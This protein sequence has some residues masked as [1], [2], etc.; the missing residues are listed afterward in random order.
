[1]MLEEIKK[2][3]ETVDPRVYYGAAGTLDD[4][5]LWDYIVFAR[6]TLNVTGGATGLAD[7]Y[8]VAIVRE[9]YIPEETVDAVIEAMKTV[10]GMRLAG[11]EFSYYYE[12][13]PKTN[14][15]LEMLVIDF[16][17]ARKS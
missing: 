8:Q 17:K 10:P 12:T 5:D 13:K 3:L 14:I 9:N 4:G 2:A 16:K 1:M 15:V 7:G 6:K 11:N